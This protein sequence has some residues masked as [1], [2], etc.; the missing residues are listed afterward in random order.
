M[1]A[2]VELDTPIPTS[3]IHPRWF[4]DGHEV[5]QGWEMS[6]NL[7]EEGGNDDSTELRIAAHD[8]GRGD[9]MRGDGRD[10]VMQSALQSI[11]THEG[12][13]TGN[14]KLH[15]AAAMAESANN[16]ISAYTANEEGRE[17]LPARLPTALPTRKES[18]RDFHT[19]G[20]RKRAITAL[21]MVQDDEKKAKCAEKK[22]QKDQAINTRNALTLSGNDDD[23]VFIKQSQRRADLPAPAPAPQSP[24]QPVFR[25][26]S[27]VVPTYHSSSSS[28][29]SSDDDKEFPEFPEPPTLPPTSSGRVRRPTRKVDSQISQDRR[30]EREKAEKRQKEEVNKSVKKLARERKKRL[31]LVVKGKVPKEDVSQVNTTF[32]YEIAIRSSK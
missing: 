3:L 28:G 18:L 2:C 5:M 29:S 24:P 7:A 8:R 15:F 16:L 21:E 30:T 14:N 4:I 17:H 19:H 27:Q 9:R 20:K 10:L 11:E 12:K 26:P 32:D 1:H 6:F 25:D 22:R 31:G 13:Y 23:V